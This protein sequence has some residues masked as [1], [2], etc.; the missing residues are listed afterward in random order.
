MA[1]TCVS[2]S[3]CWRSEGR[4]PQGVPLSETPARPLPLVVAGW[5]ASPNLC[6]RVHVTLSLSV[7]VQV[8]GH[9]SRWVRAVA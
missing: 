9:Q 4:V 6:L 7:C 8:W 1:E 3:G 5:S 2:R